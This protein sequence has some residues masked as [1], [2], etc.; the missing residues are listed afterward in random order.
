MGE[1]PP[2]H[3]PLEAS[4]SP[5]GSSPPSAEAPSALSER[6]Q[7]F[8]RTNSVES[9]PRER[10][11][12]FQ[13]FFILTV[14]PRHISPGSRG[15]ILVLL[16]SWGPSHAFPLGP[17]KRPDC[18]LHLWQE[19]ADPPFSLEGKDQAPSSCPRQE[20]SGPRRALGT[21]FTCPASTATW[22]ESERGKSSCHTCIL[23]GGGVREAL[24]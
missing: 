8:L 1:D 6:A 22:T 12:I 10:P 21:P 3:S 14:L 18:S 13:N 15:E 24:G 16:C 20:T 19:S 9:G 11:E 4:G 17:R 5:P 2:G 7:T 23:G